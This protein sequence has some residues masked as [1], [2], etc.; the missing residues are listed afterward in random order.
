MRPAPAVAVRGSGG[1]GW[2]LV[3]TLLPALAAAAVTAWLLMRFERSAWP[4]AVAAALAGATCWVLAQPRAVALVWDG[5][6]WSA[7]GAAG[8]LA[9]MVDIGPALLLRLQPVAGGAARWAAITAA[10]AGPAWHALR[11]AVYSRP[12]K[13]SPRVL[14]PERA[15]D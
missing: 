14:P 11:A 5:K 12:P 4:A 3:Q 9:V 15:A 7:D 1:L 6:Q 8:T 2:R 13:T 10:E